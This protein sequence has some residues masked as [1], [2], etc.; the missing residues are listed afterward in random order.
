MLW[1][2]IK[3]VQRNAWNATNAIMLH[4]MWDILKCTRGRMTK[5]SQNKAIYHPVNQAVWG[6]MLAMAVK[7]KHTNATLAI[8]SALEQTEWWGTWRA[9]TGEVC[10][11]A[12]CAIMS[13]P[14]QGIWE[15]IHWLTGVCLT[16]CQVPEEEVKGNMWGESV[17]RSQTNA[18]GA[19][20]PHLVAAIWKHTCS[21]I[22]SV[23]SSLDKVSLV[24]QLQKLTTGWS[25]AINHYIFKSTDLSTILTMSWLMRIISAISPSSQLL[26]ASSSSARYLAKAMHYG[27]RVVIEGIW[28]LEK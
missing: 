2:P 11:I 1:R 27:L 5:Q 8:T 23:I 9:T 18:T 3:S 28:N 12:P 22:I 19:T 6:S 13:L 4:P 20:M 15:R 10:L 7:R 25:D 24:L 26:W 17:E 21:F 16:T 14:L